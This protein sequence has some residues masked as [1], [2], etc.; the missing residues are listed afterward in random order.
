MSAARI[1]R[2]LQRRT[3]RDDDQRTLLAPAQAAARILEGVRHPL[4]YT[5][6][7]LRGFVTG[8][9]E[10]PE[11]WIR[12]I[13]TLWSRGQAMM[14][15]A[16]RRSALA[17][18]KFRMPL[19][20]VVLFLLLAAPA[21]AQ[22][23]WSD[24]K[25]DTGLAPD[26]GPVVAGWDEHGNLGFAFGTFQRLWYAGDRVT[27]FVDTDMDPQA[28]AEYAIWFEQTGTASYVSIGR[29]GG[30][31][32][33]IQDVPVPFQ[34][35]IG[36][37]VIAVP[38]AY[39]G[40]PTGSVRFWAT[41]RYLPAATSGPFDERAPDAG[42]YTIARTSTA[43]VAGPGAPTPAPAPTATPPAVAAPP[44]QPPLSASAAR[45]AVRRLFSRR[46][47]RLTSARCRSVAAARR[48]CAVAGR[49]GAWLY[50]GTVAVERVGNA[51]MTVV[52]R[53]TRRRAGCPRCAA[54]RVTWRA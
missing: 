27:V 29:W 26:I 13:T 17:A 16:P 1:G 45:G 25:G 35:G 11:R 19:L 43:G 20:V 46:K 41:T 22:Q 53:G 14:R 4:I 34:T 28:T 32:Y 2:A 12:G 36:S 50:R 3:R 39:L 7:E 24:S 6:P 49:R 38:G 48:R 37:L 10:E 40:A 23:S 44:A 42:A 21:A 15:W 54:R 8:N 5:H 9:A 33:L 18:D 47:V 52:F 51:G 30:A 31:G